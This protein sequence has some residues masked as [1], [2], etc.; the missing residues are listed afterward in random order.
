M[1]TDVPDDDG[2]DAERIRSRA[3]SLQTEE[4][5]VGTDDAE[6]QAAAIL[7]D[8]DAREADR[9]DPPGQSVEHRHSEDTVDL[10]DE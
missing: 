8:S 2:P 1:T 3:E 6:A 7:E 4:E 10:V 5:R 9:V